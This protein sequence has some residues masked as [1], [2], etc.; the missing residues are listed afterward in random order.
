M[1]LYCSDLLY[2]EVDDW[3]WDENNGLLEHIEPARLSLYICL[4]TRLSG[5]RLVV[6]TRLD[7]IDSCCCMD[8]IH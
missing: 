4:Y 1:K 8:Q 6:I 2:F 7:E 3:F 5:F